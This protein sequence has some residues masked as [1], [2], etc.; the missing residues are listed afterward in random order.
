MNDVLWMD[1]S[2]FEYLAGRGGERGELAYCLQFPTDNFK[3]I[4]FSHLLH[5]VR[6][7]FRNLV[8]IIVKFILRLEIGM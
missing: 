6:V 7:T 1:Q 4:T 5:N 2:Q 3:Y 8:T